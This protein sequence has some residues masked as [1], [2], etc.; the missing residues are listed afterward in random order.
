MS[1]TLDDFDYNLPEELI[2]QKPATPR[3]HSRLLVYNR[4]TGE[5]TDDYFYNIGDYLPPDTSLVVN[6]SKVEKCRLLFNDGKVEIFVTRAVNNRVVEAMVRP[7]KKFRSG[8]T[9]DLTDELSAKTISIADDGI[10]TI[11]LSH[12]LDHPVVTPYKHTPFPPY[13]ERD[14]SLSERY[15]T[16]YAKDSGSKAAP[17]AGL[18]FTPELLE[19]L[20]AQGIRK[21]EVTLH[22]G[23]GTFAPVKAD[24]IEDHIM[25]SEW[26]QISQQQADA[27]NKTKRV[28]AVGTTSVRVLESAPKE[29]GSFIPCSGETDIFITPGYTFKSVDHLITN[30]H[31]PKSTLLMLI[32]AFTGFDEMKKIYQHAIQQ[33]Y[34]F[35]S[36]GD[37]MLIL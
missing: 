25:H 22:V 20:A 9:V 33:N 2:A 35:Y 23:L 17:T 28:T 10:R 14:E 32:A 16:V 5:I 34:R 36:F 24:R 29:E 26:Y 1:F 3:D 37:A 15:Q 19:K 21:N 11:E 6:N 31:L 13:I 4:E 30:F 8:K 27:L 18:H 12:P 7:G